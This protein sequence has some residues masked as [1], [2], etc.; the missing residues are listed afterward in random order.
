MTS[1]LDKTAGISFV[2]NGAWCVPVDQRPKG[3]ESWDIPFKEITH[4]GE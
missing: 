2:S 3:W 4:A 1:Q